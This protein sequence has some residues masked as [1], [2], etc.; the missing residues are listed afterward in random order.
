MLRA[1]RSLFF[2]WG[3]V[4]W[5]GAERSSLRSYFE[6]EGKYTR[7]VKREALSAAGGAISHALNALH[8]V[9]KGAEPYENLSINLMQPRHIKCRD[10]SFPNSG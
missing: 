8:G 3:I 5:I 10:F 9:K 1:A 2:R 6:F 4:D 7:A